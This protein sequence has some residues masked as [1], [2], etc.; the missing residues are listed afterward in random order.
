MTEVE[1]P[2]QEWGVKNE[3]LLNAAYVKRGESLVVI[4]RGFAE[5]DAMIVLALDTSIFA[6][7]EMPLR[8]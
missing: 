5:S 1:K 2:S 7:A 4:A 6:S 8:N 3:T